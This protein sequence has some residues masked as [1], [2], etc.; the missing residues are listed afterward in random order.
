MVKVSEAMLSDLQWMARRYVD[1]RQS[2]AVRLFNDYTQQLLDLG[3]KLNCA[4]GTVFAKD[5][6]L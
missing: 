5:G 2:Y 6:G 1:G 4:D 3:V